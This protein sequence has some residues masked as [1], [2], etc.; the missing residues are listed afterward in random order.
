MRREEKDAIIENIVEQINVN[1]HFYLTDIG[2]LN[3]EDTSSLRRLCHNKGV[4]LVVVKNTLLQKALEK[5]E[6]DYDELF[7]VLKGPTA[8]M[9]TETGNAPAKLIKEF[10]KTKSKPI[11]KGAYVEESIY[12]G[13]DQLD[14][15]VSVKSRDEL[16]AD[17]VL[18]LQSPAQKVISSLQSGGNIL[19]G[20][21]ETLAKKDN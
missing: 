6:G 21:L 12:I 13:D 5:S 1:N 10:R 16:I 7:D 9:F 14:A 15:L 2:D 17:I 8:V 3:A 4:A 20:V 18:L 19:H 11:L